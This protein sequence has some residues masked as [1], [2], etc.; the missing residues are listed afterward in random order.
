MNDDAI[1]IK[2]ILL[3]GTVANDGSVATFGFRL[4]NGRE[5]KFKVSAR[6]VSNIIASF[7]HLASMLRE[8]ALT[9]GASTALAA[10]MHEEA[11]DPAT[12]WEL[13]PAIDGLHILLRTTKQSGSVDNV[14]IPTAQIETL[15]LA[16]LET[17]EMLKNFPLGQSH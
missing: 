1:W 11:L 8:K 16:L 10:Q 12:A 3:G 7:Q 4:A 14:P 2:S 6:G 9:N 5:V 13:L 17:T 15:C